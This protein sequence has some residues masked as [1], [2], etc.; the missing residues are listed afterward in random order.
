MR[1]VREAGAKRYSRVSLIL[2]PVAGNLPA[3]CPPAGHDCVGANSRNPPV[4]PLAERSSAALRIPTPPQIHE[5]QAFRRAKP[6]R[7][8]TPEYPAFRARSGCRGWESEGGGGRL[9]TRERPALRSGEKAKFSP[10]NQK[11]TEFPAKKKTGEKAIIPSQ[12][13]NHSKSAKKSAL[14]SPFLP[15]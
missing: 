13:Q 2:E 15:R 10:Q 7:N 4:R 11:Q 6:A 8:A 1:F 5:S 3:G 9:K 14:D 12:N